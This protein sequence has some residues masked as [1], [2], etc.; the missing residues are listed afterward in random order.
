MTSWLYVISKPLSRWSPPNSACC[1]NPVLSRKMPG[2]GTG[3]QAGSFPY[4]A[5]SCEWTSRQSECNLS[6]FPQV[7]D[8]RCSHSL[9]ALQLTG[10]TLIRVP[11]HLIKRLKHHCQSL[12]A[13]TQILSSS[14]LCASV[15]CCCRHSLACAVHQLPCGVTLIL[16]CNGYVWVAP[17]EKGSSNA[18]EP[19]T[20]IVKSVSLSTR[21]AICRVRNSVRIPVI[22]LL[23]HVWHIVVAAQISTLVT[24]ELLIFPA[25]IMDT[26]ST[27]HDSGLS[28]A[29]MLQPQHMQSLTAKARNRILVEDAPLVRG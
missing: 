10:G 6:H 15:S 11:P 1:L 13:R 29:E 18:S 12:F 9:P 28:S 5:H 20:P 4:V 23:I 2:R 16:G 14:R 27:S 19:E 22:L 26:Y 3:I 8:P 17:P 7:Y 25:T 24:A 21:E